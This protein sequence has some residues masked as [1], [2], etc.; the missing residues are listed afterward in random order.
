MLTPLHT[1]ICHIESIE[2]LAPLWRDL[3]QRGNASFFNSWYWIGSWLACIEQQPMVLIVYRGT[4]IVGLACL[5]VANMRWRHIIKRRV[6]YLN[7]TG[8]HE[9]DVVSIEYND[10]L[11]DE[12]WIGEIRHAAVRALRQEFD[13]IV[14]RGGLTSV[15][16]QLRTPDW[17]CRRLTEA[18]SSWVDLMA[19]RASNKPYLDH[20][21]ANARYQIKRSLRLYEA[22]GAVRLERARTQDEALRFFR[23]AGNLHQERWTA[24]GK[25]GAF[26]F[27][28]YIAMHERVIET[29]LKDGAVELVRVTAGEEPVGYLYN[30][31]YRGRVAF[32]LGGMRYEKD[33]RLKPG[34]VTHTL[35]IQ[36]HLAGAPQVYDFMAGENRYKMSLGQ[37]GPDITALIAERAHPLL[38]LEASL[39]GVKE[40]L[41][42]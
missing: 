24:R 39:R 18:P 32:Y 10:I 29:G 1:E 22:R 20:L 7:S 38:R 31:V 14:W 16:T 9:Q 30:F 23:D 26:A 37:S 25:P 13:I 11:A 42:S 3:E 40:L 8:V 19:V 12:R 6:V 2:A 4:Q 35:C 34:L 41:N 28:F 15:E 5:T 17:L 27:P 36:S 21:S 33:N